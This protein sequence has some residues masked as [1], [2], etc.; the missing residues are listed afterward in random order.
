MKNTKKAYEEFLNELGE[1]L[2][3]EKFI[4]GGKMRRG[5]YGAMMRKY[6]TIGF[7]V[8]YRD[9]V[10]EEQYRKELHNG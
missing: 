9:W 2:P 8:G 5:K 7:E 3:E 4:I 10:R 6:D 1:C